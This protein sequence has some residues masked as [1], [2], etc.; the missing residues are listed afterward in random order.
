[1]GCVRVERSGVC[2]GGA[3]WGVFEWSAVECFEWSAV[4]CV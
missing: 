2:L 4:G 3:Q 1:M